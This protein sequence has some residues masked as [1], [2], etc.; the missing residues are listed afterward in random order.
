MRFMNTLSLNQFGLLPIT[1]SGW[2]ITTSPT[3]GCL[4]RSKGLVR[5]ERG[6]QTQAEV[7]LDLTQEA[8]PA[9]PQILASQSGAVHLMNLY[10]IFSANSRSPMSKLGYMDSE[11]INRG[12][13]MNLQPASR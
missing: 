5:S 13:A 6:H 4:H 8:R 2:K 10:V 12:S 7:T 9:E 11:G 3:P 1:K